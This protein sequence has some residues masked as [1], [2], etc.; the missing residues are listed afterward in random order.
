MADVSDYSESIAKV[1]G[2]TYGAISDGFTIFPKEAGTEIFFAL[3]RHHGLAVVSTC[4][5]V[6]EWDEDEPVKIVGFENG[7]AKIEANYVD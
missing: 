5:F 1:L 4:S 7:Y 6:A 2:K 3:L